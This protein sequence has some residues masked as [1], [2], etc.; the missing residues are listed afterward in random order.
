ME[1][2]RERGS[3][4]EREGGGGGLE[5]HGDKEVDVGKVGGDCDSDISQKM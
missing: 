3:E 1:G 5:R 4:R 2:E